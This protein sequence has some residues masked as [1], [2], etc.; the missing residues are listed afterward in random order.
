M[1][2]RP[3]GTI[4]RCAEWAPLAASAKMWALVRRDWAEGSERGQLA[5]GRS[6]R[7]GD[8]QRLR[9]GGLVQKLIKVLAAWALREVDWLADELPKAALGEDATPAGVSGRGETVGRTVA[10]LPM[11]TS[12]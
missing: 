7:Q 6:R 4:L 11:K 1:A 12:R 2:H 8:H 5:D 10:D 3:R 9:K